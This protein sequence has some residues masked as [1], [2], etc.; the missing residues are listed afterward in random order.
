MRDARRKLRRLITLTLVALCLLL[1]VAAPAVGN[2]THERGKKTAA[3]QLTPAE[4][5]E[6]ERRLDGLGYWAG[7]ADGDWDSLSRHALT[8]FQKVEGRERTGRLTKDELQALRDA[9]RPQPLEGAPA[10]VEIDINRQV[11]FV[12]DDAGMVARILP[13]STGNEGRYLDHGQWHVAHTP[14]G[15]FTVERKINGWRRSTLGLL[16]YPNYISEGVAIHGSPSVP[17]QPAS[18]GCIRIPMLAAKEFGEMTPVGT[19][20]I[21]HDG[22]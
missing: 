20:V 13:V 15:R 4:V 8:A 19:P 11:L 9:S 3:A 22:Q 14:R 6:A 2:S 12:V 17:A 21:V 1:L 7:E 5:V 16:Y 18:H 10:H